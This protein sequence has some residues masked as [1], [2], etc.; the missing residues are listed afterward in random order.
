MHEGRPSGWAH[1]KRRQVLRLAGDAG[2]HRGELRLDA[3]PTRHHNVQVRARL[4]LIAIALA[5]LAFAG[6]CHDDERSG[7]PHRGGGA[8]SRVAAQPAPDAEPPAVVRAAAT[9]SATA[10]KDVAPE[11]HGHVH[12]AHEFSTALRHATAEPG[13]DVSRPRSFPLLI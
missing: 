6:L 11:S 5:V 4:L 9:A 13:Y 10:Q 12:P 3:R 8:S 2:C 7:E 1:E